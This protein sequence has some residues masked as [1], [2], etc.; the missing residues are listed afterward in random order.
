[1]AINK[2]YFTSLVPLAIVIATPGDYVT[3]GGETVKIRTSSN[4]HKFGCLG[5]YACGT[6]DS[7]HRSGRI[8]SSRETQNDI[9]RVA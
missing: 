3:R 7:W 5:R 1:M 4:E 8:F 2:A 6:S 9:V